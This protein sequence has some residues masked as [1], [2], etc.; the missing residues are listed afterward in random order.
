M[1]GGLGSHDCCVTWKKLSNFSVPVKGQCGWN[2]SV[3]VA[4]PCPERGDQK[5]MCSG[6]PKD[7]CVQA[8]PLTTS[9]RR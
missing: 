9:A 3:Q 8:A 2:L 6:P 4:K 1:L 7:P 5:P